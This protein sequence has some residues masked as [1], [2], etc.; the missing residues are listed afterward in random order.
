MKLKLLTIL[1]AIPFLAFA[2]DVS[3]IDLE[4]VWKFSTKT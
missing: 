4:V 2:Q 3:C 1:L